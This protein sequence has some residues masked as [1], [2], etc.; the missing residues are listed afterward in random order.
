MMDR[1]LQGLI[2]KHCLVYLDDIII[3]GTI[4]QEH[5]ENLAIVLERLL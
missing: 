3:F 4:I 5:N 2:G 1:A